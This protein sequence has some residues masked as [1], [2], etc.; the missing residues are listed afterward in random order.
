[1]LRAS[2][3]IPPFDH[4]VGRSGS[5]DP[6]RPT[7]ADSKEVSGGREVQDVRRATPGADSPAG[8][9]PLNECADIPQFDLAENILAE[10]RRAAS[11]RRRGPGRVE[12]D[13]PAPAAIARP[14]ARDDEPSPQEL[15]EL[16]RVV[17]EIVARDIDQLCRRSD[18]HPLG[19]PWRS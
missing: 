6:A 17:A 14:K 15:S 9:P 18:R 16:H 8:G 11:R 1:M 13:P 10:Q 3:I 7:P 5:A 2:D 19:E 12:S 4:D